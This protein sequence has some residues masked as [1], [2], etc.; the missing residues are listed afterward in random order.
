MTGISFCITTSGSN[1]VE[2]QQVIDSIVALNIPKYEV[3]FVGGLTT[4]IETTERI[5]HVPFDEDQKTHIIVAGMPGRWT[6]RKK[7]L[8]VEL[9]QYEICIIQHDHTVFD[10]NWYIEFEKF[11]THWDIC[12][13]QHLMYNGARGSGWRVDAFPGLPRGCMIPYDIDAFVPFMGIQGNYACVKRTRWLEEPLDEN[14]LWG[15]AEDMEW[16]KRVISKFHIRCN[17]NCIIK[18]TKPTQWDDRHLQVDMQVMNANA[19]YFDAIRA[20]QMRNFNLR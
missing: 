15:Q 1:D 11:G 2:L 5:K 16:S 8:A 17:P 13:H 18:N 10:P 20:T 7:N 4:T 14:R 3:L 9:S 19:A 6:T 12:V